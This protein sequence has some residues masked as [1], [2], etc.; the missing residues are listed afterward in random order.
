[1]TRAACR[2]TS[3]QALVSTSSATLPVRYTAGPWR[4]RPLA[5]SSDLYCEASGHSGTRSGMNGHVIPDRS[6]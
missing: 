2:N 4:H 1:V 5:A 3:I 6:R